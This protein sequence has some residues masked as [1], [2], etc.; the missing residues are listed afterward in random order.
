MANILFDTLH[1]NEIKIEGREPEAFSEFI[2]MLRAEGHSVKFT[3]KPLYEELPHTDLLI[4]LFP[5]KL[6]TV[7]E[8]KSIT[9]FVRAGGGLFL[10]GVW[11]NLYSSAEYLNAIA[12]NF[13]IRFQ[14]DRLTDPKHA[15][16]ED[17]VFM[18]EVLDKRIVPYFIKIRRFTKHPITTGIKEVGHYCGCSIAAPEH[19]ALAWSAPTSFSD[20]D[21]DRIVAGKEKCG[22]FIT[23]AYAEL[24]K[25]RVVCVGDVSVLSNKFINNADNKKLGLNVIKWLIHEI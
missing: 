18:G 1:Q 5:Q 24:G 22:K 15:Y 21:A 25:G 20:L 23:S 11:G 13:G 19:K 2:N 3:E 12:D 4:I 6:Y 17:V 7:V 14:S 16:E 9:N 10:L 8:I